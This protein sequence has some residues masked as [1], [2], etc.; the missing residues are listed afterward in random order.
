MRD[1]EIENIFLSH[2]S[3]NQFELASRKVAQRYQN[4]HNKDKLYCC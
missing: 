1:A 4:N 2:E 3:T